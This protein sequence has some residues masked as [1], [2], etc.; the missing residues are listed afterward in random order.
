MLG[1]N[2]KQEMNKIQIPK[3]LHQRSVQAILQAKEEMGHENRNLPRRMNNKMKFFIGFAAMVSLLISGSMLIDK[4]E[5]AANSSPQL[6][7]NQ[8]TS[9]IA[10]S[11][12]LKEFSS[13]ADRMDIKGKVYNSFSDLRKD[14]SVIVEGDVIESITLNQDGQIQTQSKIKVR[15]DYKNVLKKGEVVTFV[16]QGGVTTTG[17][18]QPV[19]VVV[20]VPVMKLGEKVLIFATKEVK[21]GEAYYL[22][23]GSFQGKFMIQNEYIERLLPDQLEYMSLRTSMHEFERIMESK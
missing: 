4:E 14:A 11:Y 16:E 23:L 6:A 21:E 1:N 7:E 2:I 5:Y 9:R 10:N 20:E 17:N 3:E 19:E 13:S 22:P 15:N 12:A 8:V 18:H